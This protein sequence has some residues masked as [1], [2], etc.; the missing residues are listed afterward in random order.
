MRELL[1]AEMKTFRMKEEGVSNLVEYCVLK[2]PACGN[3]FRH[4]MFVDSFGKPVKNRM[5]Q[6]CGEKVPVDER[7]CLDHDPRLGDFSADFKS[8]G[9]L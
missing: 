3:V 5:C 8:A 4:D 2:C 9:D 6:V 7:H 1:G